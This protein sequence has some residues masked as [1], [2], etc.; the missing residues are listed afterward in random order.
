MLTNLNKRKKPNSVSFYWPAMQRGDKL[1]FPL[2]T[3][4]V[5]TRDPSSAPVSLLLASGDIAR[6]H[7]PAART[8]WSGD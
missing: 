2:V 5:T 3:N 4:L 8:A 7:S 1:S 6:S